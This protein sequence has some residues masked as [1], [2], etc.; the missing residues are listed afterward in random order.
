MKKKV[1][2]FLMIIV[3]S[4]SITVPCFAYPGGI[5]APSWY[6]VR[7]NYLDGVYL[8]A[9]TFLTGND[10][11]V[12]VNAGCVPAAG[13]S[14]RICRSDVFT[15]VISANG[16]YSKILSNQLMSYDVSASSS[17][18][19]VE[20]DISGLDEGIYNVFLT[21]NSGALSQTTFYR[22]VEHTQAIVISNWKIYRV[23]T[24]EL[25]SPGSDGYYNFSS[26]IT[27]RFKILDDVGSGSYKYLFRLGGFLSQGVAY[28]RA[29]TSTIQNQYFWFTQ[30]SSNVVAP[31]FFGDDSSFDFYYTGDTGTTLRFGSSDFYVL[32]SSQDIQ[33]DRDR[34]VLVDALNDPSFGSTDQSG[35]ALNDATNNTSNFLQGGSSKE[36]QLMSDALSGADTSQFD[37]AI[38]DTSLLSGLQFWREFFEFSYEQLSFYKVILGLCVSIGT[39]ALV[40]GISGRV[41]RHLDRKGDEKE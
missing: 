39:I 4:V 1:F 25:V 18:Q 17:N 6:T 19:I 20:F 21:S 8:S 33:D 23:S 14:V 41:K 34:A 10:Y 29:T 2:V 12:I 32:K 7:P 36:D 16:L 31:I 28:A 26:G 30:Y 11:T 13:A 40:L 35:A 5:C 22:A 38:K 24:G 15:S 27:Y 3:I 9:P 37:N